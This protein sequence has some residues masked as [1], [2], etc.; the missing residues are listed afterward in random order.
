MRYLSYFLPLLFLFT[1]AC[2]GSSDN[3]T[4]TQGNT[5]TQASE[6]QTSGIRTIEIIGVDQ[7]KYVVRNG[8]QEGLTTGAEVGENGMLELETI[9]V[10]PGE[11]IHI[12][13][14]TQSQLPATAMAHNFVLLMLSTDINAFVQAAVIARDND[15]IPVD[16]EDEVIAHT[17][18]AAGGESVEVTFT[19][20]E[21]TGDYPFICSFP[22]HFA[23]GME[24]TLVVE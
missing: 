12:K 7:M 4:Q 20:P 19:V 6:Q 18:L 5:D 2:G 1:S 3:Q 23:A 10:E 16:R 9:S 14:T 24:G 13:L 22:G 15:Y 17:G 8:D 11:K 21:Q